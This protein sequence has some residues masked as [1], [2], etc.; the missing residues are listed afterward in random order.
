MISSSEDSLHLLGTRVWFLALIWWPGNLTS[1]SGLL[2]YL[3]IR[4]TN[5]YADKL[6]YTYDIYEPSGP[7][8]ICSWHSTE[9]FIFNKYLLK[10]WNMPGTVFKAGNKTTK[11]NQTNKT[12]DDHVQSHN[13]VQVRI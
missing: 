11:T 5:K 13:L 3:D 2:R 8:L 7:G 4:H 9:S 1:F 10:H 12:S 6:S